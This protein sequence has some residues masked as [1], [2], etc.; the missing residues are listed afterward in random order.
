MAL[1]SAT[2]I[3][4]VMPIRPLTWWPSSAAETLRV[5]RRRC[6]RGLDQHLHLVEAALAREQDLVVGAEALDFEDL[7]L[8]LGWK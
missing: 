3:L 4:A 2:V 8:D 6:R 7:L 5:G 1:G